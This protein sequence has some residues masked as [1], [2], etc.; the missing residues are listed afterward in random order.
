MSGPPP[1]RSESWFVDEW[2]RERTGFARFSADHQMRYRLARALI[3]QELAIDKFGP[4]TFLDPSI[5][6]RRVVFVLLNP[7]LADAFKPDPTVTNCVKFAQH[8][9]MNMLEIVNLFAFRTPYPSVLKQRTEHVEMVGIDPVAT[10][11]ILAA[12]VRADRVVGAWGN[13]GS[14]LS[15]DDYV[16][17]LL[18]KANVQLHHLGLTNTGHPTHPAARGKHRIP[19]DREPTR[20]EWR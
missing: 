13:H 20:W 6:V 12:C 4:V 2:N 17:E 7:S 16:R 9:G 19:I 18:G 5:Q 8:W 14:L 1:V 15:R 10:D 3:P 11:Q